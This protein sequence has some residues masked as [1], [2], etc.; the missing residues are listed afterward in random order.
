M[1]NFFTILGGMGTLATES[2]IHVLNERTPI[3]A[4][5]DYLNYLLVNHATVP[6]RTDYILGNSEDDP[7][8]AIK[9]DIQ[10]YSRFEPDFFV[11]TCNTAHHFFD[12]L[13]EET[14]IPILHMPRLAVKTVNKTF[15]KSTGKTRVGL[16]ATE[17]TI[18]TK[19]YE[20]ELTKFGNLEVVLP[21][22]AL[23]Q[24]V[25][26]LIYRDVKENHFFNEELF[27]QILR[28]MS[29][30]FSCDVMVLGCTELSLVQ[31]FTQNTKYP[32]VDAQ[33]ELANETIRRALD[34]RS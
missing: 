5:Q 8:L 30:E 13:Q 28:K 1:K 17:G 34:N 20:N 27:Y 32:V 14:D 22:A 9:E 21:D 3:H 4:D 19:V 18:Q 15:A 16:L 29:E 23:Q 33:S 7:S 31:E 24:D 12:E 6:D 10:Q 2:F 26:N 25:T 11:L